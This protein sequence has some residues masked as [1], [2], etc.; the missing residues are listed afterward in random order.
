MYN[1]DC[2]YI[3]YISQWRRC[4]QLVDTLS[5]YKM[6]SFVFFF[7]LQFSLL[8]FGVRLQLLWQSPSSSNGNDIC[9]SSLSWTVWPHY[10]RLSQFR[11]RAMEPRLPRVSRPYNKVA[12]K[13]MK[14][15]IL[16]NRVLWIE[17]DEWLFGRVKMET[18]ITGKKRI[19]GRF[20]CNDRRLKRTID[21]VN[22]TSNIVC[23]LLLVRFYCQATA[24]S[25]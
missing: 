7:L 12:R 16:D 3:C 13:Q 10:H 18:S 1:I 4:F 2:L 23:S 9:S 17:T 19:E 21:E 25:W 24:T 5:A 11:R 6:Y 15:W 8:V 20:G 22:D 14:A